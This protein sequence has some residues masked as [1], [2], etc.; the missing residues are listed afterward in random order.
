MNPKKLQ[1]ELQLAKE[2]ISR[3]EHILALTPGNVYWRKLDGKYEFCNINT[4]KT[5]DLKSHK[6]I[7][8]KTIHE[9]ID[10]AYADPIS[11][12]DE[13][14]IAS[15]KAQTFEEDAF[16]EGG[17]PAVYL[18]KKIPLHDKNGKVNGLLGIS[19]DITDSKRAEEYRIKNEAAQKVIKF[20]NLMAG[21]IAHELRTPLGAIKQQMEILKYMST[22]HDKLPKK[23]KDDFMQNVSERVIN[24]IN[25]TT[26]IIDG[27]LKKIRSFAT[28]EISHNDFHENLITTDIE[29]FLNTYP[30]KDN[31]RDL[32]KVLYITKFKYLGDTALTNHVLR[33]LMKNAL[34]AMKDTNKA[35]ANITIT[36]KTEGDFNLLIFKDTAT[37]ITKDFACKI[38]DQFETKK[39]L[40]G[41]TGLGLAF[42]K[43]VMNN[44]YNGNITCESKEG[45]YTK[46]VLSFPKIQESPKNA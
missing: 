11:K 39:T 17:K 5:I 18:T 30:F 16:A 28:G 44:C 24:T 2:K 27:M 20:S 8:G 21:S 29:D 42:C 31:E 14:V 40:H 22:N 7:V 38:F 6:D 36:T 26:Y 32:V 41:G 1:Q 35:S 12:Y 33:N 23:D 19:F 3:L 13:Q 9:L 37:G 4:A 43:N 34:H 10:K 25:E 15:D 46:F 45:G